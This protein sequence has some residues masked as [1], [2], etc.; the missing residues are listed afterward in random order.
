MNNFYETLGVS[1]DASTDDIKKAYRKLA[2]EHHPDRNQGDKKAE[3]KFKEISQAYETLGD[4]N[5]RQEYDMMQQ[6]Y[7]GFEGFDSSFDFDPFERVPD[8]LR[9]FIRGAVGHAAYGRGS[10]PGSTWR[11]A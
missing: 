11:D 3:E 6:G 9:D 4:E 7:G 5:K 8:N 10:Q 2:L 1:P